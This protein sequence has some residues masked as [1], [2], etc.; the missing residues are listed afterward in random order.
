MPNEDINYIFEAS[1]EVC[2]KVGGIYTVLSTKAK[3]LQK[4]HKDQVIFI[5][6]D[7][8]TEERPALDFKESKTI[9]KKWRET[10][11]LPEGLAVRVGRWEI[12]G[13]PIAVLVKFDAMYASKDSFTAGCGT[14]TEWTPSMHTATTTRLVPLAAQPLLS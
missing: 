14:N 7:V 6:P 10:A 2:N 3:T 12:P 1:W 13:R 5:G 9:L 4:L 8:W 11:L